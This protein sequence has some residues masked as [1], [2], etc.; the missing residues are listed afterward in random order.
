MPLFGTLGALSDKSFGFTSVTARPPGAPTIG[1]ATTIAPPNATVTT[2][3]DIPY[4][5]NF[6]QKVDL[7]VPSGTIKGV[8]VYIHGGG[9][10]GGSKSSSG[11]TNTQA[12]YTDNDE[13]QVNIV[14]QAGYVVV[15]C[16]YRLVSNAAYGYGGDGTG[17][18]PN[19]ITD[20]QT[21]LN[22]CTVNNA[23]SGQSPYWATIYNYV[24][25]YGFIVS[26]YSA[27]GHLAIM[28]VGNYGTSSGIWPLAACSVSGPMDLNFNGAE[29]QFDSY[30]QSLVNAFAVPSD[31]TGATVN[32]TN[33]KTS[34]PR[35]QY[36]YDGV[37]G[38]WYTAL[39]ASSCKF[40]FINN[41]NDT[42]TTL[43]SVLPF[44]NSLPPTKHNLELVT[45]GTV[46][47]GVYSHN[48]TTSLSSHLLDWANHVFSFTPVGDA[49]I[50]YTAP[51]LDGGSSILY[52]K[53]TAYLLGV[54]TAFTGTT[55]GPGSGTV[56][57]L[58]LALN[59]AY[60]F[61]VLAHSSQGGD[62][63]L[64]NASNSITTYTTPG[65][66]TTGLITYTNG[67]SATISFTAPGSTGGS[68]IIGYTVLGFNSAGTVQLALYNISTTSPIPITG[69]IGGQTYTF[70]IYATTAV[71]NSS[72]SAT[73]NSLSAITSPDPP[74]AVLVT[75]TSVATSSV[76][77]AN[78]TF[79]IPGNA[80][81]RV[82]SGYT[83]TAY[84]ASNDTTTGLTASGTPTGATFSGLTK[85]VAYTFRVTATN[86]VGTSIYSAPSSS[87][88]LLTV[89]AAPTIGTIYATS[90]TSMAVPFTAPSD[91]G[92]ATITRYTAVSTPGG[93][94]AFIS[95][96]GS[97]TIPVSGLTKGTAYTFVVYA[98]NSVGNSANS[99]PI[100]N[101]I[102]PADPP[103]PPTITSVSTP[104]TNTGTT[105][106]VTVNYT[107]PGDNGGATITSYTSVSAPGSLTNTVSTAS[108]GSITV[109]G[110]TKG[111][112]YTFIVYATNRVGNS[113]NS[114]TSNSI[115][116]LTVPSIP[117]IGTATPTGTTSVNV[118]YT[119]STDNGGVSIALIY[120]ATAYNEPA[121]TK[122]V[123][124]NSGTTSPIAITGLT[125]G[126]EYAFTVYATN[127]VGNTSESSLSNIV[128]TW[129]V[130][131]TPTVGT[132]TY[133]TVYVTTTTSVTVPLTSATINTNIP[134]LTYGAEAYLN[135]YGNDTGIGNTVTT[136]PQ[137]VVA[138]SNQSTSV[139]ISGLTKGTAY[140]FKV[141]ATNTVG[142][143]T[144]SSF[145]TAV[146]PVTV[147]GQP[148]NLAVAENLPYQGNYTSDGRIVV[149]FSDPTDTGGSS[150]TSRTINWTSA[151]G[152][153]SLSSGVSPTSTT[154]TGL[155]KGYS[156][157]F[158]VKVTNA[159]GDSAYSTSQ[160]I[161]PLTVPGTP[162]A[163]SATATSATTATISIT[164]PTDT[165]GSS[166]TLYTVTALYNT[167]SSSGPFTISGGTFTSTTT[168]AYAT[169]LT[170]GYYYVFNVYATNAQGYGG[171][172]GNSAYIQPADVPSK[173]TITNVTEY[174]SYTTDG[175]ANVTISTPYN[176]GATIDS[177]TI[178][179]TPAGGGTSVTNTLNSAIG[180]TITV[181]GM[182]KGLAY[183]FSG[184][185]HNRIGYSTPSDPTLLGIYS[186]PAA[187]TIGTPTYLATP[188]V[189]T[190]DVYL[191]VSDTDSGGLSIISYNAT[192][193]P[194]SF[195]GVDEV[196]GTVT[197][198]R[199]NKGTTYTFSVTATNSIVVSPYGGTSPAATSTSVRPVSAPSAPTSVTAS[200]GGGGLDSSTATLSWTAPSDTGG[201]GVTISSYT[202]T[203]NL[204]AVTTST[205]TSKS[206]TGLN[207]AYSYLW[208]VTATNNFSL[209][210]A[211]ATSNTI[212]MPFYTVAVYPTSV[213]ET[214]NNYVSVSVATL[215]V[216]NGTTLYWSTYTVSGSVTAAEFTDN[217]LTGSFTISGGSAS[218]S[219]TMVA[220]H[221]TQGNRQWQ[222]QIRI[223]STS[224]TVEA[225]S[226]IV[227]VADTSMNYGVVSV[228][229]TS[230]S[231]NIPSSTVTSFTSTGSFVVTLSSGTP[232]NVSVSAFSAYNTN[233]ASVS[234]STFSLT[235]VGQQQTVS[236]SVSSP[237]GPGSS[238]ITQD[239]YIWNITMDTANNSSPPQFQAIQNHIQYAENIT[240]TPTSGYTTT[241]FTYTVTGAPGTSY[242]YWDSFNGYANRVF[243]TLGGFQ[244]DTTEGFATKSGK[245][246]L[247]AGTYTVYVNWLATGDG[248]PSQGFSA[249]YATR[250][251]LSV[252]VVYPPLV[253]SASPSTSM[254]G[255][256]GQ[257]FTGSQYAATG[258]ASVSASGGSGSGYSYAVTSGSL[259][260]GVS[261]SSSGIFSGTPT[262]S[263]FYSV[264]VTA[265]DGVG[266]TG[267]IS[268]S[269][270]TIAAPTL[271]I[272]GGNGA[273]I[274][275]GQLETLTW[276]ST[277]TSG[278]YI[279]ANGIDEGTY[280]SN[281]SFPIIYSVSSTTAYSG[282][283]TPIAVNG[284]QVS[285]L[286]Q[287]WTWTVYPVP[288]ATVGV[289]TT[290]GG[291]TTATSATG[292]ASGTSAGALYFSWATTGAVSVFYYLNQN[293]AGFVNQGSLSLS[294]NGDA[295]TPLSST[296]FTDQV[297]I[298]ATNGAGY[299]VQS[300]T[301]TGTFLGV[302]P[303]VT[304]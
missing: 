169:G 281:S 203:D 205:T 43:G 301:A 45:E 36:Y 23:G 228:S 106:S 122:T 172:S 92:G 200:I 175:R 144:Y 88:T 188:G 129:D 6:L 253:V 96:A 303:V 48:Y 128:Y 277:G 156:Y 46:T 113:A 213:N 246:W 3:Y 160:T 57:V 216:P 238:G 42:L 181:T 119:P 44:I 39:N 97:G 7:V 209:T 103:N 273:N 30:Q 127:Q 163:P 123:I 72:S 141:Y 192:S 295:T 259:P 187:P 248:D 31:P 55:Y 94:T 204:G 191:P 10:T 289:S 14:A 85:G 11:F 77:T 239:Y 143:S 124:V 165:G 131:G 63:P 104:T 79:T 126:G 271:T 275:S 80:G 256:V 98:T 260:G 255:Q 49:A 197:V 154:V 115:T 227:T 159:Q 110:L 35:Y 198:H 99:N 62:G 5:S 284:N 148:T 142:T 15:N 293:N 81:G 167:S 87:I 180:G 196:P 225:V 177:Y 8:V 170:Q 173:P 208:T 52:Y 279:L 78:I 32:R 135:S 2:T 51:A 185:A 149:S 53:A 231:Q 64:S 214:T 230:A 150:I 86:T 137:T 153:S 302:A 266:T 235:Y 50:T 222:I 257:A 75:N 12:A 263:S 161:T 24:Q 233:T 217:T 116:P 9:W 71:G 249:G 59:T 215:N 20:I 223:G 168:T 186:V 252:T 83:V 218:F 21:I 285:S 139:T 146:T 147:P 176:G 114:N 237:T 178:T 234:P 280:G 243:T 206:I 101:S 269:I 199:L 286:A 241:T 157:T 47:S 250:T 254:T 61:K 155:S 201:T 118:A 90:G 22:Y 166:I 60:T 65:T 220:D 136:S 162:S 67:P 152:N 41:N 261:L 66:P 34:S 117:T 108:S 251:N 19:A 245:Y 212:T 278:V 195:T 93:I 68:P 158:T 272:T 262:T 298:V 140:K 89:P 274:T 229:P 121:A 109:S 264:T 102:T 240:V 17:G 194:G 183:M 300:Q 221:L 132:P 4:G 184:T 182:I 76:A 100:S 282:T 28:G 112:P 283:I 130:P 74:T 290:S 171:T 138:T 207:P 25:T 73:S 95:Q 219:R 107:A 111:T 236:Y 174:S 292:Y 224:G 190:A 151:A 242:Y 125:Q 164:A 33:L 291:S 1:T 258:T 84:T 294:G 38:P 270:V 304:S 179:A 69:L 297:Y 202:I 244:G 276:T 268:I 211:G 287:N 54:A 267:T 296:T 299:S 58:G 16:N 70:K 18:Y 40:Y 193:S 91:N 134:N 27:G 133:S 189:S 13:A 145:S 226:S 26:G 105:S 265:T 29:N 56:N 82:I 247:A 288:T 232:G 210:S 37:A 120:T